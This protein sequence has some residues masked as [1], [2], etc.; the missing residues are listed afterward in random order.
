[1]KTTITIAL[2]SLSLLGFA[3]STAPNWSLNDCSSNSHTLYNY[4]DSQEVVVMEFGMGC[5]GCTIAAGHLM[6][7]KAQYD[8]SHPG[9]VNWFYMDYWGNNCADVISTTTPYDFN[10]VFVN[11]SAEENFYFPSVSP[12]PGIVIAAGNFH[13]VLYTDY[14]WYNSDTTLIKNVIDQFFATVGLDDN[15]D[16]VVH[17]F[18]NP[19]SAILNIS[20]PHVDMKKVVV[21]VFDMLGKPCKADMQFTHDAVIVSTAGLIQGH[22]ICQLEVNGKMVRRNFVKH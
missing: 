6:N 16:M 22:Y 3:Q 11:C 14:S 12:M 17:L 15:N 8:I 13:T 10:A 19:A 7:L 5:A 1:M 9:K 4:L 21:S 2:I 18:P 20:I